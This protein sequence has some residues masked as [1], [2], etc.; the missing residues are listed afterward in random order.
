MNHLFVSFRIRH[1][2][3]D[4]VRKRRKRYVPWLSLNT[5]RAGATSVVFH[6]RRAICWTGQQTLVCCTVG[7][8]PDCIR[9]AQERGL[10]TE[11]S[12]TARMQG[13]S[14]NHKGTER[15][16]PREVEDTKTESRKYTSWVSIILLKCTKNRPGN[17][18]NTGFKMSKLKF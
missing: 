11:G 8:A 1:F 13:K 12:T 17:N 7:Q 4:S 5:L 6:N 9:V 14:T 3:K 18:A 16:Q 10:K 15:G 2:T